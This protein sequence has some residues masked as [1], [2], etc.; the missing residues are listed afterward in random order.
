MGEFEWDYIRRFG[1][2][3]AKGLVF[4][5]DGKLIRFRIRIDPTDMQKIYGELRR[6]GYA[7]QVTDTLETAAQRQL[8]RERGRSGSPGRNHAE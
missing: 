5:A 4:R 3:A 6:L 8:P 2:G 1:G 7:V